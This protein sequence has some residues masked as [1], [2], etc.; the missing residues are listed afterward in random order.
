MFF[1]KNLLLP[2]GS[3]SH[4]LIAFVET[5]RHYCSLGFCLH[6]VVYIFCI[7]VSALLRVLRKL[8][9]KSILVILKLVIN[10]FETLTPYKL[11]I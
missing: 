8:F 2:L 6:E 9:E 4:N 10:F 5:I 11:K 3:A 1:A 7:R